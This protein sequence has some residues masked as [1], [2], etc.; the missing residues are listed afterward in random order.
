MSFLS[1]K[2]F[3]DMDNKIHQKSNDKSVR[4]I[5]QDELKDIKEMI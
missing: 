2:I 4:T 5:F 3:S 1:L